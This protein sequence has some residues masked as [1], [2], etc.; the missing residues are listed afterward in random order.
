MAICHL[1]EQGLC[2]H[3]SHQIRLMLLRSLLMLWIDGCHCFACLCL[4]SLESV[5]ST[6]VVY[7]EM[8]ECRHEQDSRARCR[9]HACSIEM[10]LS[11]YNHIENS[12]CAKIKPSGSP[13]VSSKTL[14]GAPSARVMCMEFV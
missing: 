3:I 8:Q 6:F 1:V 4:S 14:V 13:T 5:V 9:L 11:L 12:S 2:A 7:M 10:V